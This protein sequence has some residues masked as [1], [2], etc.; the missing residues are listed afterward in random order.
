MK[1]TFFVW[2]FMAVAFIV[3]GQGKTLYTVNI[4]KPKD[5]QKYAFEAA[6]KTHVAKFHNTTDKRNVYEIMSGPWMG[7]SLPYHPSGKYRSF[8]YPAA[9]EKSFCHCPYHVLLP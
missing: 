3:N 1:K 6:W 4:V 9:W 5:G 2:L 8:F 7:Y